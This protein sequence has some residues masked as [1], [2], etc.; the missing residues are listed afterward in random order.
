MQYTCEN[1]TAMT[2]PGLH[3]T[4]LYLW[5]LPLPWDRLTDLVDLAS[6]IGLYHLDDPA[7][8]P[9]QI[10]LRAWHLTS[11]VLL[12]M[13][14]GCLREGLFTPLGRVVHAASDTVRSRKKGGLAGGPCVRGLLW[15]TSG[16]GC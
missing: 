6:R 4:L 11:L 10:L 5:Q 3:L 14:L 12:F 13:A 7:A 15:Y 16:T 2:V 8:S 9:T 1:K